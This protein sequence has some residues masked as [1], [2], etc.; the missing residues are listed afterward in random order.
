MHNTCFN[1]EKNLV[2]SFLDEK[3]NYFY[4]TVKTL[5]VI[6]NVKHKQLFVKI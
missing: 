6:Y 2:I 5:E 1:N 3:L 4:D